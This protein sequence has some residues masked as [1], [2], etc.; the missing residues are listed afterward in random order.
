MCDVPREADGPG[1]M[2][3]TSR[4]A[5]D[6]PSR[7]KNSQSHSSPEVENR[8][9]TAN[10]DAKPLPVKR[11]KE[12]TG[13]STLD[14]ARLPRPTTPR[15]KEGA[16]E[17]PP[18]ETSAKSEAL[19]PPA[20]GPVPSAPERDRE[21]TASPKS[22][23]QVNGSRPRSDSG[24]STPRRPEGLTKS[25]LPELLSPLHPSLFDE[26]LESQAKPKKKPAEKPPK[27]EKTDNQT[28]PKKG[29][30]PVKIPPLLS[31]TLPPLV[32]EALALR[33]RRQLASK[34]MSSQPPSH[35]SDSPGS[36]RKTTVSA[37][38]AHEDEEEK[39]ARPSRIV[40]LKLKKANAKRAKE[41]LSLP[42][43]AAKDA[44]RRER[45]TSS[46]GHPASAKRPRP[47]DDV[48]REPPASKRSR[49]AAD[50]TS[51]KPAGPATHKHGVTAMSRAA[52][53]QSQ[54]NPPGLTPGA[55]ERPPTRSESLDPRAAA[56][57]ETYK[58]RHAEFQ[59]LGS[60]LKHARDD[61]CRDRR[62]SG[63]MTAADERRATALH[64]EM[65]LAY[66]VAF[67]SLNQA[68]ALERKVYEVSA[69]ESLL[70][71]FAELKNR[72]QV[73]GS[74]VLQLLAS[75][76]HAISLEQILGALDTLNPTAAS[77]T[78]GAAALGRYVKHNRS[79]S[80]MWNEAAGLWKTEDEPVDEQLQ[81]PMGPWTAVES[82]A[83]SALAIMRRWAEREDVSWRPELDLRGR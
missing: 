59:R 71:H 49:T 55:P 25:S 70:P 83:V 54:G 72:V 51:A 44:L 64:F 11:T 66:M 36:A 24:R 41:L 63:A 20:N 37:P 13:G 56:M 6:D 19:R 12:E 18:K 10:A 35:A 78:S 23:I 69:W 45:P 26:E 80:A 4:S 22:T 16:P 82:A 1:W 14:Q 8:K 28:P 43:K 32:E 76:L 53:S 60:K 79:R 67:H 68:R 58:E 42:S 47:A 9:R 50:A 61:L 27:L 7:T 31:P 34:S 74:R 3:Q 15:G 33:E 21:N 38:P 30:K 46:E 29:K 52:S 77:S 75:Q 48:L 39:S 81:T 65:V 17:K 40:T 2:E 73:Q 57:V 5:D 62:G